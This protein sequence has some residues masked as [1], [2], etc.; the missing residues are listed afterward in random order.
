MAA[1]S[2]KGKRPLD[3]GPRRH[4]RKIPFHDQDGEIKAEDP[5]EPR[6]VPSNLFGCYSDVTRVTR[7]M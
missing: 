3:R 1:L 4:L 7:L 6:T 5:G 2:P